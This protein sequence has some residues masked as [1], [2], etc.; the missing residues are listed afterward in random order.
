LDELTQS[1]RTLLDSPELRAE[2]GTRARQTIL[3]RFT[4]ARQAENLMNIY[5]EVLQ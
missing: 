3:D 4:L 1:L 5:H 2:L